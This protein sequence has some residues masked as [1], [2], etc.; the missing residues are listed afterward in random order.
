V[1]EAERGKHTMVLFIFSCLG[2]IA[3][4]FFFGI[5]TWQSVLSYYFIVPTAIVFIGLKFYIKDTPFDLVTNF[6]PENSLAALS[7]IAKQNG[8]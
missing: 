4:G 8:K 3:N 6:P 2:T 7:W 1:I 5:L